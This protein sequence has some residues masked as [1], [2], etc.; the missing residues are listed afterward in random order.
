MEHINYN[1]YTLTYV[2]LVYVSRERKNQLLCNFYFHIIHAI[3]LHS[4]WV[5][6]MMYLLSIQPQGLTD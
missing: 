2:I 6:N 4:V 3:Y 1:V 5:I